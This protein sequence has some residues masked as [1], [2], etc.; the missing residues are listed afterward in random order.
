MRQDTPRAAWRASVLAALLLVSATACGKK[1]ADE[2][3]ADTAAG[4]PAN[5]TPAASVTVTDVKLGKGVDA[6]H[7]VTD[8]TDEFKP[9]DMIY[10]TVMTSGASPSAM[11]HA[12]WTFEDG[13]IVDST[14]QT[15]APTGD[16]ATEF[17]IMKPG[18]WPKG[19]YKLTVLVN[20][21]E[22]KTKEFKVD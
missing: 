22:A 15:I 18:G 16:A 2:G 4:T 21:A 6:S 17:H 8:E 10:A 13:Q 9:G 1:D 12:R 20:G 3:A 14:T 7:R 11:V 19:K 5:A